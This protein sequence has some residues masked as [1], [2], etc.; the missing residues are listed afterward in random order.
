MPRVSR[1]PSQRGRP[2]RTTTTVK[3]PA[4]APTPTA[5]APDPEPVEIEDEGGED[6]AEAWETD[7]AGNP[8]ADEGDGVEPGRYCA[9]CGAMAGGR[10]RKCKECGVLNSW[11]RVE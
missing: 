6:E 9:A 4:P 3:A 11:E 1:N 10:E 8:T 5:P 7:D 2:T